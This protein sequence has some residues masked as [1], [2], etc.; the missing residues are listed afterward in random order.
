MQPE[1]YKYTGSIPGGV[2]VTVEKHTLDGATTSKHVSSTPLSANV[3]LASDDLD[4]V[5]QNASSSSCQSSFD[6]PVI[7]VSVF[8][9]QWNNCSGKFILLSW[10]FSTCYVHQAILNVSYVVRLSF[11][12]FILVTFFIVLHSF[13]NTRLI[14]NISPDFA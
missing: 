8:V 5:S 12:Q 9:G 2:F 7:S 14:A 6:I 10:R 4:K 3:K 11:T 1:N 13:L